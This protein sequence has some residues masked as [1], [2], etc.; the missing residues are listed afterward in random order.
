[1]CALCGESIPADDHAHVC[2]VGGVLYDAHGA[3]AE[4]AVEAHYLV[5]DVG[6]DEV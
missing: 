5:R 2:F 4:D 1:M 6:W 3:C